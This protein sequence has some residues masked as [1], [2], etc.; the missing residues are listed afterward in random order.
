MNSVMCLEAMIDT[1]QPEPPIA[2]G[3]LL[4]R[5]DAR[6]PET[7]VGR[8]RPFSSH[9]SFLTGDPALQMLAERRAASGETSI[10]V[11]GVIRRAA[12]GANGPQMIKTAL[13]R[14][15]AGA[16]LRSCDCLEI[17]EIRMHAFLTIRYASV[18]GQAWQLFQ[19]RRDND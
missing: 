19:S 16:G 7:L 2:R 6:F 12:T 5:N 9:W 17:E 18:S 1:G 8:M 11:S 15:L 3:A 14:V 4:I 10:L 13:E